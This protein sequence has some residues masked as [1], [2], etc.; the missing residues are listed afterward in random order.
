MK[1][2]SLPDHPASEEEYLHLLETCDAI[3]REIAEVEALTGAKAGECMDV[4][5]EEDPDEQVQVTMNRLRY[6]LDRLRQLSMASGQAYFTRLDFTP[7]GQKP[8]TWY[9]GRWGVLDP[10]TLTPVVVDWRS[11]AA[12]LYYSGQIGRM[13]YEAP[14]GRVEGELTLKR[15]LTVKQRELISLFDS[16]IVSQEA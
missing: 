2:V 1:P 11:P 6:Q 8:E 16:G 3:D 14:D 5:M 7:S 10:V 13:D 4:R 15:M 12:N 9:L